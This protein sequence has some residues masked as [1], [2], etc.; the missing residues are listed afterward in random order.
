MEPES[1]GKIEARIHK[2]IVDLT[3]EILFE[4]VEEELRATVR[5]DATVQE[6]KA[7]FD[8]NCLDSKE[9]PKVD[10]SYNMGWQQKGS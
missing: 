5:E 8:G 3:D 2:Y 9:Y 6:W 1:F 10:A 7:S 4:N